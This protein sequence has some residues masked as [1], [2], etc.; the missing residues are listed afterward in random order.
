MI[1]LGAA[2]QS[3]GRGTSGRTWVGLGG[4][5]FLTLAIPSNPL[6]FPITLLSL[7][8]G[9]LLAKGEDIVVTYLL[10]LLYLLMPDY[11]VH[12]L[13]IILTCTEIVKV[14][15]KAEGRVTLKWPNDVLIGEEKVSGLLIEM[16]GAD[17]FLVGIG[18]NIAQVGSFLLLLIDRKEAVF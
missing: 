14:I 5:V 9:I 16:D 4:N 1:A 2:S 17:R 3:K 8:I 7:R 10:G 13:V 15:P 11:Q 6:P 12:S 18:V